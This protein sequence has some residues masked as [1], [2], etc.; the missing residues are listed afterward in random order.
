MEAL[1]RQF[2]SIY[3]KIRF[4]RGQ[5]LPPGQSPPERRSPLDPIA[6][7]KN[8]KNQNLIRPQEAEAQ[9]AAAVA[10]IVPATIG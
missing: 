6:K 2:L 8:V 9:E 7:G 4:C 5:G 10:R 1:V 3:A